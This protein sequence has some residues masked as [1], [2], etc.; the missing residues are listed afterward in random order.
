MNK[1]SFFLLVVY[2][3][4][5]NLVYAQTDGTFYYP[6]F[7]FSEKYNLTPSYTIVMISDKNN[8]NPGEP[9]NYEIYISGMGHIDNNKINIF[10]RPELLDEKNPGIFGSTISC[11]NINGTISPIE[12]VTINKITPKSS[13]ILIQ[14]QKCVFMY[15]TTNNDFHIPK[16]KIEEPNQ[17]YVSP[18]FLNLNIS[19]NAPPGDHVLDIIFTYGDGLNFYQNEKQ[20]LLHINNPIERYR[21]IVII[22]ITIIVFLFGWTS[23]YIKEIVIKNSH[24]RFLFGLTII[25]IGIIL[26]L[27]YISY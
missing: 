17:N 24:K 26:Y 27:I 13:F 12:N 20:I 21:H 3:S 19:K 11:V 14:L 15:E 10:F 23:D 9:I 16:M 4:S 22:L 2:F 7:N 5:L 8:I 18:I 6:S 1:T 25:V